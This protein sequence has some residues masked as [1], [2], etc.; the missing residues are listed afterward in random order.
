MSEQDRVDVVASVVEDRGGRA[1]V[2]IVRVSHADR[3]DPES[4]LLEV[5]DDADEGLMDWVMAAASRR[6]TFS[7]PASFF[8]AGREEQGAM[9][10]RAVI[11][12]RDA[13]S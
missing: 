9:F 6:A 10:H 12:A 7:V 13:D 5:F 8:R 3:A 2:R 1:L 11:A 4:A